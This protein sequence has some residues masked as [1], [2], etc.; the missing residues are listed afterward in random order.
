MAILFGDDYEKNMSGALWKMWI[1]DGRLGEV[2][3]AA[4]LTRRNMT[5][6]VALPTAIVHLK[7][8]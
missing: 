1:K 7:T 4:L 8:H 3:S 2:R 5:G 6:D